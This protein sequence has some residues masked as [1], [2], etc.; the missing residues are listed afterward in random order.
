M[1][2]ARMKEYIMNN[3]SAGLILNN[4]MNENNE[5]FCFEKQEVWV[6]GN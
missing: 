2:T 1:H 3:E 6:T 4:T 5:A